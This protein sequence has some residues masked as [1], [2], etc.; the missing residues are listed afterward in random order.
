[1]KSGSG[2]LCTNNRFH[3]RINVQT[4]VFCAETQA[5]GNRRISR[6]S[7]S[8]GFRSEN[9]GSILN[10]YQAEIRQHKLCASSLH[11]TSF[12][13]A[14]SVL[15]LTDAQAT[16]GQQRYACTGAAVT[17]N[18]RKCRKVSSETDRP[19]GARRTIGSAQ[20]KSQPRR[21]FESCR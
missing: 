11:R 16:D 12:F 9:S 15:D 3:P 18:P 17:R 10:S 19:F 20:T 2:G 1:M 6:G 21:K 4:A 14:T 8:W 7:L 5:T 13:I